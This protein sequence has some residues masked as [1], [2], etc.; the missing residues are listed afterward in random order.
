M[1]P[2]DER[3]SRLVR[4]ASTRRDPLKDGSGRPSRRPLPLLLGLVLGLIGAVGAA[5]GKRLRAR[6]GSTP[7]VPARPKA[8]TPSPAPRPS[9]RSR[10]G[11]PPRVKIAAR[12]E[13]APE[14]PRSVGSPLP[15][16]AAGAA[17]AIV[18]ALVVM[19]VSGS[20]AD[21]GGT[22]G[23]GGLDGG[24]GGGKSASKRLVAAFDKGAAEAEKTQAGTMKL[25]S[26][27]RIVAT[28]QKPGKG[29]KVFSKRD[30]K[31]PEQRIE[32]RKGQKGPLVFSATKRRD[33]WLK[34][35]LPVRPNGSTGWIREQDVNLTVTDWS[36]KMDLSDHVI[37]VRHKDK[38][39]GE[40]SI[41]LGQP[42]TPTPPGD[43]YVTELIQPKQ[44]DTIYGAY[45]FVLSGYSEKLTRFAGGNGE[46]GLH[47]TNDPSGLGSDV[48]H[49][50]IRLRNSVITKLTE[51]LPLGTPIQIVE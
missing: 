14:E 24:G 8:S 46:L 28:A 5:I 27:E 43:Y 45:V 19:V 10:A 18:S 30:A 4:G 39:Y 31:K 22:G 42:D 9:A 1:R 50:C 13:P 25:E 34:V 33:G 51:R 35:E 20:F 15:R 41:G 44:P 36:V 32:R 7:E 12:R 37:S 2:R 26:Y 6:R 29:V 49:G 11:S 48:S 23:Q 47:G 40:W 21:T 38:T 17:V 3:R 16:I